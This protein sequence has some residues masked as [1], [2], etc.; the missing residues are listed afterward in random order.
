MK[1]QTALFVL[2]P[3]KNRNGVTSY[4]VSGWLHGERIRK[5]FKTRQEAVVEKSTL[6]IKA[7]QIASGLRPTATIL[8]PE[9]Q[10][11]A[12]ALF[13][14]IKPLNHSLSFYVDYALKNYREVE[15]KIPLTNAVFE[16]RAQRAQD[17]AKGLISV[18]Q[19]KAIKNN[20]T[21]LCNSFPNVLVSDITPDHLRTFFG[22]GNATLKTHNNRRGIVSTFLKFAMDKEWISKNPVAKIPQ[23]RIAH[24]RGSAATLSANQAAEL[25]EYVETFHEGRLASYFALCLFA[26]IRPDID[27]GEIAK[28]RP[29]HINLDTKVIR[30]E[31]EVSKVNMKRNITIQPNLDAWLSA[32]P[33]KKYPVVITN[34]KYLRIRISKK[35]NLTH[36]VLRHTFISM[37]V[38]KF[39]SMGDTALQAGNSE[40]IIRKHYLDVKSQSEAEV[41]FSIMP[42]LR[43]VPKAVAPTTPASAAP[44]AS[45]DPISRAA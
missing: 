22:R 13:L 20:M 38:A 25:M 21:H 18:S 32:Y 42:K 34:M 44:L 2:K 7:A 14:K 19:I 36:D 33:L 8:S 23:Y 24:K 16:Y 35:F 3:F 26:G 29:E 30:I 45:S 9:Q 41:F 11:E 15:H 31:P 5:N 12:E 28:L 27:Q 17:H 43:A 40:E 4:R 39:R 6:E 10:S 37:H 1:T